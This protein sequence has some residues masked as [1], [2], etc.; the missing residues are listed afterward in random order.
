M[1]HSKLARLIAG[2]NR[3]ANRQAETEP[4]APPKL[5]TVDKAHNG[6]VAAFVAVEAQDRHRATRRAGSGSLTTRDDV[7]ERLGS[8]LGVLS[9][10]DHTEVP[11]FAT[12][13]LLEVESM[14]GIVCPRCG[15]V[16]SRVGNTCEEAGRIRRRHSCKSCGRGW[17]MEERGRVATSI[18]RLVEIGA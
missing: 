15:D 13:L 18:T 10:C 5:T 7:S 17:N 2:N 4:T 8:S 16:N 3:A 14:K 11:H 1:R 9:S 6:T 12:H